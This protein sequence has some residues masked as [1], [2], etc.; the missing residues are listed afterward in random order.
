VRACTFPVCHRS[1][2]LERSNS[3]RRSLDPSIA[4]SA[5]ATES[6]RLR[7]TGAARR[8][9]LRRAGGAWRAPAETEVQ[10]LEMTRLVSAERLE[11][12]GAMAVEIIPGHVEGLEGR[13]HRVH[14]ACEERGSAGPERSIT[15]VEVRQ[16]PRAQDSVGNDAARESVAEPARRAVERA[17]ARR[18]PREQPGAPAR[19]IR[20]AATDRFSATESHT[21]AAPDSAINRC[22]AARP[23]VPVTPFAVRSR[24]LTAQHPRVRMMPSHTALH[25]VGPMELC[26]RS[27]CWMNEFAARHSARAVAP[28]KGGTSNA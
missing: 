22:S 23:T 2:L 15:K 25:P 9:Y 13:K 27:S 26:D 5:A 6:S 12:A 10:L 18:V 24:P 21:S 28:A 7:T 14:D 16:L 8:S 3:V 20:A 4:P 17:R 1:R 11:D 19:A